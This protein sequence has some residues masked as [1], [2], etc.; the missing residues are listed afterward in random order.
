MKLGEVARSV[1]KIVLVP[2]AGVLVA[3]VLTHAAGVA[4]EFNLP[5]D[6]QT[7][8]YVL[9]SKEYTVPAVYG[10][11]VLAGVGAALYYGCRPRKRQSLGEIVQ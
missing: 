10:S 11:A 5:A 6:D 9:E 3:S 8:S 1:G 7:P 2:S 4:Y